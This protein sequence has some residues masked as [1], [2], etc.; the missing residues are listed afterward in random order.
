MQEECALSLLDSIMF[1]NACLIKIEVFIRLY[2]K[3]QS[4]AEFPYRWHRCNVYYK[5]QEEALKHEHTKYVSKVLNWIESYTSVRF[6]AARD[7]DEYPVKLRIVI[8]ED[9]NP[10]LCTIGDIDDS[11]FSIDFRYPEKG[12]LYCA[13]KVIGLIPDQQR[14]I[15]DRYM[16]IDTSKA[17]VNSDCPSEFYERYADYKGKF[18]HP[19]VSFN[20]ILSSEFDCCEERMQC[21]KP[22]PE[23]L[24]NTTED[25]DNRT[26]SDMQYRE[27]MDRIN[28]L[29]PYSYCE[30]E[31]Q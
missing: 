1:P 16:T 26:P 31:W 9:V 25:P 2:I 14:T 12:F 5:Y 4:S 22:Y 15:R 27:D 28:M 30:A 11:Y 7:E 13:L 6:I 20:S 10:R 19:P 8:M 18:E 3:F 29:Y 24:L 21:I 23:R 17:L